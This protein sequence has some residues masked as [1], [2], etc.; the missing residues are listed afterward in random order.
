MEQKE[1]INKQYVLEVNETQL[2]I[3]R[4]ALE[5]YLRTRMG[6]FTDLAEDIAG[7]G[8]N[9]LNH[10]DEQF[11][12]YL[13]RKDN[14]Q[15]LFEAAFHVAQPKIEKKTER[16]LIAEDIW[17]VIRHE[18]WKNMTKAHREGYY[19]LCVDAGEPIQFSGQPLPKCRL[20]ET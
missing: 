14:S 7:V 3:I 4:D 15:K 1:T 19:Y 17:Q 12:D 9:W 2:R 8:F 11:M 20:E 6:Q 5:S 16:M 10:T 13:N 18:L